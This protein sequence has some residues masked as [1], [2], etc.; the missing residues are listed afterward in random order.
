MLR[1]SCLNQTN[2]IHE[3][4]E[5]KALEFKMVSELLLPERK[6]RLELPGRLRKLGNVMLKSSIV[7]HTCNPEASGDS[8]KEGQPGLQGHTGEG[9]AYGQ[10][11]WCEHR[12]L[13]GLSHHFVSSAFS[14]KLQN[15]SRLF[16][17]GPLLPFQLRTNPC[18]CPPTPTPQ[19]QFF[20]LSLF[21]FW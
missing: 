15:P 19:S 10:C 8:G 18:P 3:E 17:L 13:F 4:A 6:Q 12:P 20:S 9:T 5:V 21:F 1:C 11:V 7:T 2:T 14:S 16:P